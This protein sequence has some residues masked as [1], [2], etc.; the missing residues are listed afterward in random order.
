MLQPIMNAGER[1]RR[2]FHFGLGGLGVRRFWPKTG[3]EVRASPPGFVLAAGEGEHL[4]HFRD[5]A[6]IFIPRTSWHGFQN[7]DREL[8]LLWIVAPAGLDG[9]FRETCNPPAIAPKHFT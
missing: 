8:L 7:P 2:F 6:T 1:E 9:F 5:H 4:V 3:A